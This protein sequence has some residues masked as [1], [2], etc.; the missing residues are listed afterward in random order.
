MSG[1][2]LDSRFLY[3]KLW[4]FYSAFLGRPVVTTI[5]LIVLQSVRV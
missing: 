1:D 2:Q 4:H 5:P 3:S